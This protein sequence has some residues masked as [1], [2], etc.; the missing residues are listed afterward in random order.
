VADRSAA[1]IGDSLTVLIYESAKASKSSLHGSHKTTRV[2]GAASTSLTKTH[3]AQA[4]LV[5]EFDGAGQTSRS[6]QVVA[7]ISV[8][9]TDILGNGDLQVA[10][11]QSMLVNGGRT[12]IR[13]SGR[14]RP[15]DI[16]QDNTV[17]SSRIADANI[18]YDGMGFG[19][20]PGILARVLD[21]LGVF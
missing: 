16:G 12:L 5:G 13:V 15:S 9:V 1:R 17:L 18:V 19:E 4:S 21:R 10:G 3:R 11:Q 6:D 7:S 8:V 14:V 2:T 20:R